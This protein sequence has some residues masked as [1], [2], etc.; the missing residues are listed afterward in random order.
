MSVTIPAGQHLL[1][2]SLTL[3]I[4]EPLHY[5]KGSITLITGPNGSGKSTFFE[6]LLIPEISK[7]PDHVILLMNQDFEIQFYALAA[8]SIDRK[9]KKRGAQH[10]TEA[11]DYL[12][13]A[14]LEELQDHQQLIILLDEPT[15]YLNP[16][17]WIGEFSDCEPI[18]IMITHDEDE[19]DT[20]QN[21]QKFTPVQRGITEVREVFHG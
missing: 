3:S 11:L 17:E 6:K 5:Q 21:I 16:T 1:R 7:N 20:H 10:T 8:R 12:K 13:K 19:I 2:K 4:P 9:A 18:T 15:R 14:Y